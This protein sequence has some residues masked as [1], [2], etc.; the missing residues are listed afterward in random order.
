MDPSS[1]YTRF[2]A[3]P[4]ERKERQTFGFNFLDKDTNYR[5][6][7]RRLGVITVLVLGICPFMPIISEYDDHF[8]DFT[9]HISI[10]IIMGILE[11][12][13]FCTVAKLCQ[14]I[15]MNLMFFEVS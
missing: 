5:S 14:Q 3:A 2:G 11:L 4:S 6:L 10:S 9:M 8:V 1:V 13:F 7:G 12:P 15:Q